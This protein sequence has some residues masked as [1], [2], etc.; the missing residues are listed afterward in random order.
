MG[1]LISRNLGQVLIDVS[2]EMMRG[3][4][5]VWDGKRHFA[6]LTGWHWTVDLRLAS[7]LI[8]LGVATYL[9]LL[10]LEIPPANG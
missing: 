8:C 10:W 2:L 6:S 5:N 3:Y 1:A 9:A 7:M 4:W